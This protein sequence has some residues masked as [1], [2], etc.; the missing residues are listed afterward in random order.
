MSGPGKEVWLPL[1]EWVGEAETLVDVPSDDPWLDRQFAK[2]VRR[3]QATLRL[4]GLPDT[5]ATARWGTPRIGSL[6]SGYG[7]LDLSVMAVCGGEPA[8]HAEIDKA[9]C[10]VLARHWPHVPN[11]GDV[12]KVDWANVPPV[13]IVCG[14]SP[15]TN[16]STAGKRDGFGEGT[17]SALWQNMADAVAALR[18]T[19]V[20]WENVYGALSRITRSMG[21]RETDLGRDAGPTDPSSQ[22]LLARVAGDLADSGYDCRWATV[23]ASDAGLCHERKRVFLCGWAAASNAGSDPWG[24]VGQDGEGLQPFAATDSPG[25]ARAASP[26]DAGR[27]DG[28]SGVTLLRDDA[29]T[30]DNWAAAG[31][32]SSEQAAALKEFAPAIRLNEAVAGRPAPDPVTAGVRAD[33]VLSARWTEWMMGLPEGWVTDTPGVSNRQAA[34]MCGL[35]VAPPQAIHA[36]RQIVPEWARIDEPEEGT[37]T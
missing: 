14:G 12:T 1:A 35:G 22:P 11:L 30:D 9:A 4:A 15:C 28:A 34:R 36:L 24:R 37:T 3:T 18:P 2:M 17:E 5:E 8:W 20:I 33:A 27:D 26:A 21:P 13:D 23:R 31:L 29:D 7:G 6:F 25:G 19:L 16:V 10:R 32:M